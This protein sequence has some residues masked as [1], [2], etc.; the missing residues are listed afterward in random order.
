MIRIVSE[1]ALDAATSAQRTRN[2][3]QNQIDKPSIAYWRGHSAGASGRR[4]TPMPRGS[5]PSMAAFTS[6]GARNASEWICRTLSFFPE[7]V[8]GA[9][10]QLDQIQTAKIKETD[11]AS[12]TGGTTQQEH[13]GDE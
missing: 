4:V 13:R 1:S 10:R 3:C 6:E 9:C 11:P 8:P 12:R 7:P 2:D 5:F